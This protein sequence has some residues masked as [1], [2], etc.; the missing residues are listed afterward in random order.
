VRVVEDI[1]QLTSANL[2]E[3]YQ[4][5]HTKATLAVPIVLNEEWFGALIANQCRGARHW[6]SMEIELLQQMSEQVAIA[7]QQ[8]ELYQELAQLN[9]NLELQ[10]EER[11]AELQQKMQEIQELNRIKDVVLHTVSHDLRTTVMGNLMVLNNLLNNSIEDKRHHDNTSPVIVPYKIIE[12]MI[13]GND[14]Q[15]AMID[16]LLEIHA[17]IEQGVVLRREAV[18]LSTLVAD[19]I[20]DLSHLIT[21]NQA[22]VN[23]LVPVDLPLVFADPTQL[24]KV[25]V[26]LLT[27]GLQNNPP[28][29]NLTLNAT[30]ETAVVRCIIQDNGVKMSKLERDRLF[31]LCVRDPQARFSTSIG[32][33]MFL[34]RQ[35]IKAHG[36]EM[37]VFCTNRKQ[38]LTL[39]FTLPTV[40]QQ[41]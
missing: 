23:N 1:T 12:R 37:G 40:T 33:K 24:Q 14:R 27:Q 9:T 28:G 20:K 32:L 15:L 38:G 4:E 13:Q 21:Q 6:T 10:V 39:W 35:I 22:N 18:N 19:T 11:T 31:D 2:L 30:V 36:G 25:F 16:S 3:L 34:C 17:S 29:L 41:L 8:A 26:T 5:F 7:I